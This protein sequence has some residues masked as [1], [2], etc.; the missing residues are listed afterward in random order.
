MIPTTTPNNDEQTSPITAVKS[1]NQA[2]PAESKATKY[3][4]SLDQ[5]HQVLDRFCKDFPNC[6][7]RPPHIKPLAIGLHKK[8]IA[9][10]DVH[11]IEGLNDSVIRPA[12]RW[13][14][15]RLSYL[16]SLKHER[17]RVDLQGN[18]AEEVSVEDRAWAIERL[19]SYY[20]R[21][22]EKLNS[23]SCQRVSKTR[24]RQKSQQNRKNKGNEKSKESKKIIQVE[25]AGIFSEKLQVAL[26]KICNYPAS[27]DNNTS[28]MY[29]KQVL[30]RLEAL[31]CKVTKQNFG[32][33]ITAI[34]AIRNELQKWIWCSLGIVTSHSN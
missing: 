17:T 18:P 10:Y 3:C 8:L 21:K 34:E 12:I 5:I 22:A 1:Q 7:Q 29:R 9:H 23:S 4:I 19:A 6:F 28:Q 26:K 30:T 14:T 33:T 25:E 15:S 20:K 32:E 27:G 11:P 24:D 16:M 2:V 13:Y 31:A